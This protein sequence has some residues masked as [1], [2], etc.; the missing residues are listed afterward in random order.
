METHLGHKGV[1]NSSNIGQLEIILIPLLKCS[2]LLRR[3]VGI[4]VLSHTTNRIVIY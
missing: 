4:V 1:M 2:H 3:G